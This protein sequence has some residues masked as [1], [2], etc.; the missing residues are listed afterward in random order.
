MH[1]TTTVQAGGRK[2]CQVQEPP[3]RVISGVWQGRKIFWREPVI[4]K[5]QER[6]GST[7]SVVNRF[8]T[9]LWPWNKSEEFLHPG[10]WGTW[11]A[12]SFFDCNRR[13]AAGGLSV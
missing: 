8:S 13:S 9:H 7:E 11:R 3:P 2:I 1:R 12:G 4:R 6:K 5:K 10:P